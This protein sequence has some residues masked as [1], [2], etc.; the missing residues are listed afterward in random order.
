MAYYNTT[1]EDSEALAIA[2]DHTAKQD[3]RIYDV[4]ISGKRDGVIYLSPWS[5]HEFIGA[6]IPITSVRRSINTLT[7]AGKIV[8][9]TVKVKGPYGR[10]CYCWKLV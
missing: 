8:K 2:R 10:P 4:F 3:A 1:N 9:T 7:K 5:V 6:A